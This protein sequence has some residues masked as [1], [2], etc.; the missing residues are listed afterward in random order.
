M[1]PAA[2]FCLSLLA[3]SADAPEEPPSAERARVIVLD[4]RNDGVPETVPPIVR[5][6]LTSHLAK[7]TTA[8]VFST[9]DIRRSLDVESQRQVLGCDEEGCLAEIASAMGAEYIFFGNVGALG[10]MIVVNLNLLSAEAGVGQDRAVARRTIEVGTLEELSPAVRA[11]ASALAGEVLPGAVVP[12][13]VAAESGVPPSLLLAGGMTGLGALVAVGSTVAAFALASVVAD[14]RLRT[15]GGPTIEEKR[16]AQTLG[17]ISTAG[18]GVGALI[19]AVGLGWL[20]F[21]LMQEEAP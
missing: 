19:A 10:S 20:A 1:G 16:T 13:P 8:R 14:E 15:D 3:V 21:A 4:F 11:A 17:L 6:V 7:S 5:D 12:P 9:E 18:A 2:L